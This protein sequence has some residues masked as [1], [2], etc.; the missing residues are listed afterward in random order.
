MEWAGGNL[1]HTTGYELPGLGVLV[2]DCSRLSLPLPTIVKM[3][4]HSGCYLSSLVS[5]QN[6][7]NG[8]GGTRVQRVGSDNI[9][10]L[11]QG[12]VEIPAGFTW[13]LLW[14]ESRESQHVGWMEGL[15]NYHI[16]RTTLKFVLFQV[17]GLKTQQDSW[18]ILPSGPQFLC[19]QVTF[20]TRQVTPLVAP[21]SSKQLSGIPGF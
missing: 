9:S 20:V 2:V 6:N 21:L 10:E 13:Q 17:T 1:I 16:V 3:G 8:L 11:G 19:S 15:N 14:E 5:R 4:K 7:S 18:K 12:R